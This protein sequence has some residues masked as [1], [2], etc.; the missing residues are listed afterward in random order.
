MVGERVEYILT[1]AG[2][3]RGGVYSR[4]AQLNG[5]GKP[6]AAAEDLAVGAKPGNGATVVLPPQSFGIVVWPSAGVALCGG[7]SY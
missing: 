6:L 3:E 7:A 4:F 1:A 5:R 2:G